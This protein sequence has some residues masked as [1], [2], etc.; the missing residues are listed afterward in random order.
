MATPQLTQEL[1]SATANRLMTGLG[2]QPSNRDVLR[3]IGSGSMTTLAK[4]MNHWR[5]EASALGANTR[6]LPAQLL[7]AL[8]QLQRD[9]EIS[10][11]EECATDLEN[12]RDSEQQLIQENEQLQAQVAIMQVELQVARE[13]NTT[14]H[15]QVAQLQ[16]DAATLKRELESERTV[17]GE[18]RIE[19]AKAALRIEESMPQL[20]QELNECRGHLDV[21][22]KAQANAELQAAVALERAAGLEQRMADLQARQAVGS[23]A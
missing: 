18:L 7:R 6:P 14:A 4:L 19:L 3:E 23:L 15:A 16:A 17:A 10:V 20:R 9:A 5:S 22:R 1:V 11:R 8:E 2:K 21:A 13:D 12:A